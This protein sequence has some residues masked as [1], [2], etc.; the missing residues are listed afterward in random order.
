[1]RR[2]WISLQFHFF[3]FRLCSLTRVWY[4]TP[5]E[6]VVFYLNYV[7][8]VPER[9]LNLCCSSDLITWCCF[10]IF[11]KPFNS[12]WS[13]AHLW[14]GAPLLLEKSFPRKAEL[15]DFAWNPRRLN[16]RGGIRTFLDRRLSCFRFTAS[17]SDYWLL[18]SIRN[19]PSTS[20]VFVAAEEH[21]TFEPLGQETSLTADL[22]LFN[23]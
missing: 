6:A 8:A 19:R 21:V 16:G 12:L 17:T 10:Y 9:F 3:W 20:V 4:Q 5:L 15:Q 7:Y 14:G 2:L 18:I 22:N 13:A 23:H 11:V 1:M